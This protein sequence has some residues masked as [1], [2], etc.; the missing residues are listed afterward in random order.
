MAGFCFIFDLFEYSEVESDES[1]RIL[2]NQCTEESA[3]SNIGILF[4]HFTARYD[5]DQ[6]PTQESGQ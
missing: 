4:I 6:L 1:P 2:E 3:G 5:F